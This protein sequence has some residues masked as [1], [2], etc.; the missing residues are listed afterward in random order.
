MII[1]SMGEGD[2]E[3]VA[4]VYE[5]QQWGKVRLGVTP[6]VV[7]PTLSPIS[8]IFH[9]VSLQIMNIW[10]SIRRQAQDSGSMSMQPPP[11]KV[12]V[13]P[14]MLRVLGLP[15]I[16]LTQRVPVYHPRILY[17]HPLHYFHTFLL[18]FSCLSLFVY[19]ADLL[20][21]FYIIII[22]IAAVWRGICM[23]FLLLRFSAVHYMRLMLPCYY[24]IFP[25]TIIE[26]F[27]LII[28]CVWCRVPSVFFF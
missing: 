27:M 13:H 26:T 9:H 3:A 11:R 5:E 2:W 23:N 12:C 20:Q 15:R 16:D 25:Y 17:P 14:A 1:S 10:V 22:I 7:C 19:D 24:N 8:R 18:K 6:R 4:S 28:I 21:H